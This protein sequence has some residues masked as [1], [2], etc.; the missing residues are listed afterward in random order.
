MYPKASFYFHTWLLEGPPS[1]VLLDS[2]LFSPLQYV[3]H[4]PRGLSNSETQ[5]IWV[6]LLDYQPTGLNKTHLAAL[7]S[8][9]QG[10]FEA[11]GLFISFPVS[12]QG[13]SKEELQGC[14]TVAKG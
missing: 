11:G 10:Y 8:V 4:A 6:P 13:L 9:E 7:S 3:Q 5:E 1:P 12:Y 2:V 14:S